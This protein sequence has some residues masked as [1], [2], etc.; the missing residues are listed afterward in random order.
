MSL[1]KG[2]RHPTIEQG[3]VIG[4]GA[5]ILGNITIGANSRIGANSVVIKNVPEDSTA[6]GIPARVIKKGPDKSPYSHNK[7]PNIDTEMFRYM[8]KRIELL[9]NALI[10]GDK[11]IITKDED[12]AN[13]YQDFIKSLDK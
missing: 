9:E 11:D 8:L 6:V 2:K 12:L 3:V 5:K 10:S 13:V 1:A 7:L 4:S